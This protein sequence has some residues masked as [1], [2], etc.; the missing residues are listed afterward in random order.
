MANVSDSSST[1]LCEV[2]NSQFARNPKYSSKQWATARTCSPEC[3][4]QLPRPSTIKPIETY[5]HGQT[6]FGRLTFVNEGDPI[7]AAHHP[8]RR[9]RFKCD[10]GNFVDVQPAKVMSRKSV[11]CG[12]Y[13]A[14]KAKATFTKHGQSHT[15]E[16]R[17]WKSMRD[18]CFNEKCSAY[19]QYG[20]RGITVC[21]EWAGKDGLAA[22]LA[23]MGPRPDG[24]SL[25]RIDVDGNYEPGNVRWATD[26]AQQNNKRK[27]V[28]I[29]VDG[30][31]LSQRQWAR[32]TGLSKNAIAARIAAGW[33][34]ELAATLPK[35]AR[36]P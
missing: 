5:L 26:E 16:Y 14:E 9:A 25:D 15:A 4:K 3:R 10:C 21:P 33:P 28:S 2:C 6:R 29:T 7:I 36:K 20:G 32:K 11:S 13:A 8:I 12:C 1:R 19:P 17:A 24:H 30:V 22:F 18:R 35:G 23:Y 31:T 27:T 34:P